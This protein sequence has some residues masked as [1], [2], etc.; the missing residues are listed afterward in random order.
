MTELEKVQR[1]LEM[2]KIDLR[3]AQQETL[4]V[5][6]ELKRATSFYI[7]CWEDYKN[8]ECNEDNYKSLQI[9]MK[10]IIKGIK[11]INGD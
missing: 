10:K 9:L 4:S 2:V 7:E 11:R 8:L 3:N 5:K 1:E 6:Y